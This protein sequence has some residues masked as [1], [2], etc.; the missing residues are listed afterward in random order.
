MND[1]TD[2]DRAATLAKINEE[3][4]QNRPVFCSMS[5]CKR[6]EGV[7]A[8]TDDSLRWEWVCSQCQAIRNQ[9]KELFREHKNYYNINL[10]A[11]E[12]EYCDSCGH[13]A[14]QCG[15][16]SCLECSAPCRA[17]CSC[18]GK[19]RQGP[20]IHGID[21]PGRLIDPHVTEMARLETHHEADME[22]IEY[23]YSRTTETLSL[24]Q[25]RNE[26]SV[27]QT[28]AGLRT[29]SLRLAVDEVPKGVL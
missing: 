21:R 14:E 19:Y 25:N 11:F 2:E 1:M 26:T 8:P 9:N 13:L 7:Y 4:N 22:A 23:E 17:M 29:P 27:S 20:R 6:F 18:K 3:R 16:P 28:I 5:N 10:D 15:C 12:G 24:L